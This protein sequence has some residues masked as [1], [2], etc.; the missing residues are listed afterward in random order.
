[1]EPTRHLELLRA[2]GARI[3][4]TPADALDL[5]IPT[6]DGWTV[7][8]AIRH[9]GKVHRWV[10]G[11]IAGTPDRPAPAP[12]S[13]PAGPDCIAAYAE[14]LDEVATALE[15]HDPDRPVWTFNG[16]GTVGWWA[17]RQ[18][19]EVAVHR[20]DV[21]DGIAAGGGPATPALTV[22]GAADG[23]DEF[24]DVFLLGFWPGRSGAPPADDVRGTYHLHGT[25]DPAPADGA[26]WLVTVADGVTVEREHAKGDVALRGS[27]NDLLLTLW[28][29]RPLDGLDVVGDRALAAALLD[30]V[31][32]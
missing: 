14:A 6:V 17:R 11:A 23:I 8:R 2:E 1:M 26:E 12:E 5:A 25:D 16:T 4:A 9:T 28:R 13:L 31:R 22:D 7:E 24:F 20:V 15:S 21:S 3:A 19:H 30:T 10:T 29:R 18:A 27:S 32:I